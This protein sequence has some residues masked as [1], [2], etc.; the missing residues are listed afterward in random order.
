[1]A[2]K[3]MPIIDRLCKMT[4]VSCRRK[5]NSRKTVK[6]F[7]FLCEKLILL[8]QFNIKYRPANMVNLRLLVI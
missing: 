3:R 8:D 1:M 4:A 2:A 6:Y 5:E 7:F